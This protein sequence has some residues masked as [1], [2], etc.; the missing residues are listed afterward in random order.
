MT[1]ANGK[2]YLIGTG[3]GDLGLITVKGLAL[4]QEADVVVGDLLGHAQLLQMV[5]PEAKQFDVGCRISQTKI[6]QSQ[7]N[8]KLV[9]AAQ[10][11]KT[12]VRLW[13]GDPFIFGRASLEVAAAKAAGLRVEVVPG[14]SSALAAPAYAGIPVT[15]WEHATSFA[16]V[17]GYESKNLQVKTDWAALAKIE[18]LVILMPL[19][20]LS[21]IV[22]RLQTAGRSAETPVVVIQNGTKPHQRQITATLGTLVEAVEAN[23]IENP[24]IAVIGQ[25]AALSEE[26]GW[27]QPEQLPLLGKR[28]LVTRPKHQAA[29]FMAAL[30]DLG[31]EPIPFPTIEIQP[32]QEIQQLDQVLLNIVNWYHTLKDSLIPPSEPPYHWI[33]LTSVNGVNAFWERL[34]ALGFDSRILSLINIAAIGPTTAKALQQRSITP[35]LVPDVYTAEGVLQAFEEVEGLRFLL[36]RADIARKTLAV[37][38]TERGAFVQEI[39]TYRTVP[40]VDGPRPP[41][42]DIVTFTS[43]STVQGF[44]NCLSGQSPDDALQHSQVVCIGPITASTAKDLGVRVDAVADEYTI[45]GVLDA[46]Q[47]LE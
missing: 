47:Q 20:D 14:V 27:Y 25:V 35:D 11:G 16:V 17:T 2:I 29:G 45:E 23:Q 3:P 41:A 31:A 6:P 1:H 8:Q 26:L 7:I 18:T 24:A 19:D 15:E 22:Q 28:V 12:V 33:V 34:Q 44:V 13:A 30:R 10:A 37:G 36:P 9:D 32:S 46:L 5:R 4:I 39:A 43:S 21:Q 40:K 38:L 42:A